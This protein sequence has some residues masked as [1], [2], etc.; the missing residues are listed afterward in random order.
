[1]SILDARIQFLSLMRP[2]PLL[3]RMNENLPWDHR[4]SRSV[5][6]RYP[7]DDDDNDDDGDSPN[8]DHNARS[9]DLGASRVCRAEP[10]KGF[11]DDFSGSGSTDPRWPSMGARRAPSGAEG[12]SRAR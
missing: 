4:E 2:L 8:D 12:R 10:E 9:P 5:R 3:H 6:A 7:G 1:M 11:Y